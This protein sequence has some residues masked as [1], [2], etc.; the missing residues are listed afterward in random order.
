MINEDNADIS[1]DSDEE[2]WQE[3]KD[4]R[5][6]EVPT[7]C[8]FCDSQFPSIEKAVP[9][10]DQVHQFDLRSLKAKYSMDFYSYIRVSFIGYSSSTGNYLYI[11]K[12]SISASELYQIQQNYKS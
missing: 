4:D 3:I 8:L 12:F 11:F 9:H 1:D 7:T 2:K 10:L 6:E 5:D